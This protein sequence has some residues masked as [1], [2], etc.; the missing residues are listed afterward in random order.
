MTI[1]TE[2]LLKTLFSEHWVFGVAKNACQENNRSFSP[3]KF[4]S[5]SWYFD[6]ILL[7]FFFNRQILILC[8]WPL[9]TKHKN[10]SSIHQVS[11]VNAVHKYERYRIIYNRITKT[12]CSMGKLWHQLG[13]MAFLNFEIE[14]RVSELNTEYSKL[15]ESTHFSWNQRAFDFV[16]QLHSVTYGHTVLEKKN[17]NLVKWHRFSTWPKQ[18]QRE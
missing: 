15:G 12:G 14:F 18:S 1:I 13:K 3:W 11:C 17:A 8:S 6:C 7:D 2:L 5:K 10:I 9:W 4:S 16:G